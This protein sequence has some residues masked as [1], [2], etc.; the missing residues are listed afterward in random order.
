VVVAESHSQP[1]TSHF[2]GSPE[3]GRIVL[4]FPQDRFMVRVLPAPP[5]V[6][7][8]LS[9]KGIQSRAWYSGLPLPPPEGTVPNQSIATKTASTSSSYAPV[10]AR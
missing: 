5:V 9:Q 6:T 3:K 2:G 10:C 4:Q 7:R 8:I 1:Q